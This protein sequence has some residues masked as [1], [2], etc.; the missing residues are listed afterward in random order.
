MENSRTEELKLGGGSR[1][2]TVLASL[3]CGCSAG[4]NRTTPQPQAALAQT[5]HDFLPSSLPQFPP[6]FH[7]N[8]PA[9]PISIAFGGIFELSELPQDAATGPIFGTKCEF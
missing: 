4:Y 1:H 6:M 5:Y 8:V 3:L 7:L 9:A 2:T